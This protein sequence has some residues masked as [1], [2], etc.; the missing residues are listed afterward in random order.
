MT[1]AVTELAVAAGMAAVGWV[2][3]FVCLADL[4]RRTHLPRPVAWRWTAEARLGGR[5]AL[6]VLHVHCRARAVAAR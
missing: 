3:T 4:Q 2:A 5:R 1:H 6:R